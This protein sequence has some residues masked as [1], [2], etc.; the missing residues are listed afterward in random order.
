MFIGLPM[1]IPLG[2]IFLAGVSVSGEATAITKKYQGKLAKVTKMTDIVTST[3]AVFE[4]NVSRALNDHKIDEQEFTMLQTLHLEVLNELA[5][6][7]GK[8]EAETRTQLQKILLEEVNDLKKAI[9]GAIK[10]ASIFDS[11]KN[12]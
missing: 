3:L 11:V 9:K 8:M 1:S 6:V 4:T 10:G 12:R 5:N 2:A 7:D